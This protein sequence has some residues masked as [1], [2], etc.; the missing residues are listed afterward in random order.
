LIRIL[1]AKINQIDNFK[2]AA[3]EVKKDAFFSSIDTISA[4]TENK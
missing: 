4:N 3:L 2:H 1:E